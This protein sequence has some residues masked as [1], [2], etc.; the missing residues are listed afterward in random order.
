MEEASPSIALRL[1]VAEQSLRIYIKALL[2]Y[3]REH[4]VTEPEVIV[5]SPKRRCAGLP[6]QTQRL[7]HPNVL[8]LLQAC[9]P[10]SSRR[11]RHQTQPNIRILW[12]IQCFCQK[13]EIKSNLQ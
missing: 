10:F 5:S 1:G 2:L 9:I 8:W 6:V 3:D 13:G 12:Q 4:G 7:P 11:S